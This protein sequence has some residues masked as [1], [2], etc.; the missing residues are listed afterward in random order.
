MWPNGNNSLIFTADEPERLRGKQHGKLW[1][2]EL[3]AWRYPEAWDQASLGL[4]IGE[5]PQAVITTTPRPTPLVRSLAKDPRTYLT[6][7]STYDNKENLA[8][9]FVQ[10]IITKYE[11]TRLGRQELNAEILEDNP[12]ALWTRALIDDARLSKHPD[13]GRVVVA[14]DPAVSSNEQSDLTGIVC[15]G[16]DRQNPPH[17]YVLDDVSNIYTPDQWGQAVVN[18][19]AKRSADRVVAEINQGGD[20][21]EAVLRSKHAGIPYTAVRATR[22]KAV[23]AEPVAALYEQGR[24]HHIG[25]FPALEDQMCDWNPVLDAKSPDRMDALVWGITELSEGGDLAAYY[26]DR[27]AEVAASKAPK[28]PIVVSKPREWSDALR[29]VRMGV[30][31]PGQLPVDEINDW[32]AA[33]EELGQ[34]DQAEVARAVLRQA[35]GGN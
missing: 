9:A 24:V 12:G 1:C 23:R 22:G 3:A 29:S 4:R 20:M 16:I 8:P 31:P 19:Y 25:S 15:C 21:V 26:H 18:L 13:L 33:C 27:A 34:H 11:G 35:D 30:L 14:V 17:F 2:D 32:I 5:K 6:R 10:Q 28:P 7:G